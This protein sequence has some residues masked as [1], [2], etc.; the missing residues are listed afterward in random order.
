MSN[1]WANKNVVVTGGSGLLGTPLVSLL[2]ENGANVFAP[3]SQEL[4]LL[5]KE[6]TIDYFAKFVDPNFSD[7]SSIRV[8]F[9]LAAKVGGVQGNTQAPYDFFTSNIEMNT[10]V[11]EA[12][13]Q[14]HI[15]KVVSVLSTC[16][17]PDADYVDYPLTEKQLHNGPPHSS[18]YGYAY[19]KRM[20][21]VQSRAFMEQK[22]VG[23]NRKAR[24]CVIPNNLFGEYDN[25]DLEGGH[26]IPALIR[27]IWEAKIAKQPEVVIWGDGTPLREFTYATDAAKAMLVVAEQYNDPMPMN[28]GCTDEYSISLIASLISNMLDYKGVLT[29]DT[30]KPNGQHRK[31]SSNAKLLEMTSWKVSDY[32]PFT[33]ALRQTCEWF[34]AAYPN[35]RGCK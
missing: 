29:F 35:V 26:V 18:N 16:V 22:G 32:T 34:V 20:L 31:P 9:H 28:I 12:T 27:K 23:H 17:Y 8:V 4:N 19:A 13:R 25:F 14:C 6:K 7:T 15:Q 10:N 5:D 2:A 30:T 3:S 21:E 11:M 1:Y 33:R 24:L